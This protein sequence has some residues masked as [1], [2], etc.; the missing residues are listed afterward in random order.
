MKKPTIW[1]EPLAILKANAEP[2]AWALVLGSAASLLTVPAQLALHYA[3]AVSQGG[4]FWNLGFPEAWL[5]IW[6]TPGGISLSNVRFFFYAWDFVRNSLFW[7]AICFVAIFVRRLLRGEL[8]VRLLPLYVVALGLARIQLEFE[9]AVA[10]FGSILRFAWIDPFSYAHIVSYFA[11]AL[12]LFP[13]VV[14]LVSRLPFREIFRLSCLGLPIILMPPILDN[15]VLQRPVV[16]NFYTPEFFAQPLDPLRYLTVVSSTGIRLEAMLVAALTLVYLV[17][18]T[19]SIIRSFTAVVAVVAAF[20]AVTTPIVTAQFH[21]MFSQ[22]QFFAGFLILTY[23]LIV[24]DLGLAQ[25]KMGSTIIR[26]M[27]L[28]GIHFPAMVIFAAFLVHPAILS[29]GIP[30]DYGLVLAAGFIAF[31]TWQAAAVFDD[32]YDRREIQG[33]SLYL[34]YG[35]LTA[36]MAVLAAIPFGLFPWLLTLFAA[37]LAIDYPRLRRRHYLLSGVVIGIGSAISFLFGTS[38]PIMSP[39]T[40][41]PVGVIALGLFAVFSG[42]SLVKDIATVEEDKRSGIDTVFTKFEMKK[43]LPIVATFVAVGCM[44]PIVFLNALPDLIL[45]L[46]MAVAA[47]LL[48]VLMRDKSYRPVLFLYFIEGLWI[49][50]EMFLSH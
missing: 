17:Y 31:L 26:R 3:Q 27:R 2:I 34:G 33:S 32:I 13:A 39:A 36:L 50:Y 47:W 5:G 19:R 38:I 6:K 37:Y 44:L 11:M 7:A 45:F 4:W 43:A 42:G 16:Y 22:P 18:R 41:Q 49:F 48:I 8:S 29:A 1:S 10:V 12:L 14:T 46:A 30:A 28:R 35:L 15:Y 9:M 24:V 20:V 40:S 25:P 23:I 21:L